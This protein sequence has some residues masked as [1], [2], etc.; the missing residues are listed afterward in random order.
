MEK[1]DVDCG[2][3][4]CTNAKVLFITTL[5]LTTAFSYTLLFRY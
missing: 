1:S 3:I 4:H 2:S 5:A